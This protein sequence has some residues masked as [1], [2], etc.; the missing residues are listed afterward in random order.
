MRKKQQQCIGGFALAL[1]VAGAALAWGPTSRAA[2]AVV[3]LVNDNFTGDTVGSAPANYSTG[4]AP[5]GITLSTV[6]DANNLS[7]GGGNALSGAA[8]LSTTYAQRLFSATTLNV[9]DSINVS[10]DVRIAA[11]ATPNVGDRVFRF[12]LY[13]SAAASVGYTGR[14]DTG[15]PAPNTFDVFQSTA[16]FN[17]ATAGG[18]VSL[19]SGTATEAALDDNVVRHVS[20]TLTRDGTGILASLTV[21]EGSGTPVTITDAT[22]NAAPANTYYT[23]DQFVIGFN[24]TAGGPGQGGAPAETFNLDNVV[25][26]YTPVPEPASFAA[27]GAAAACLGLRRRRS[28]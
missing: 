24:G 25:I 14:L 3:P 23:L 18:S 12:G 6:N 4:G 19:V 26:N 1:A 13:N 7:T 21:Q 2:A 10:F 8:T 17:T 28:V 11:P 27:L 22:A 16:I 15:T 9:G 5:N 20:M